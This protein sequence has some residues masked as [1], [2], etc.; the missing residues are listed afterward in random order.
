MKQRNGFT[1]VELL[2]VIAIIGVLVALLLPA[3]QAARE[4][5]RRTQCVNQIRQL[6][7]ACHNFHD[8]KKRFPSAGDQVIEGS[9]TKSTGLSWLAYILP[10]IEGQN[11]QNLV[12]ESVHWSHGNNDL[13]E[14]TVVPMFNCPTTGAELL[15]FTGNPGAT[16]ETVTSA[17][18]AQYVGIMGAKSTCDATLT[19]TKYPE[20]GYSMFLRHDG[21]GDFSGG[22]ANNG[23]IVFHDKVNMKGISDG[24]SNT[25]MI[26]E[27]SWDYGPTR[28]WIIGTL[29][30]NAITSVNPPA[31][32]GWIYNAK[33]V[34]W[35]MNTAYRE[36]IG[37]PPSGYLNNDTSLG[38][39]HPGGAHVGMGDGSAKFVEEDIDLAAL[40][41]LATRA[42]DDTQN[43]ALTCTGSGSGG[44]GGR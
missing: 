42:N 38:S 17:L 24:T 22:L 41:A 10:Y 15:I 30:K 33:N 28:S 35:P 25:M 16:A 5:A 20:S 1:L 4:A 31:G 21:S 37:D 27:S 12:D 18:R 40:K 2:V 8:S 26:G 14:Q 11:L 44:G 34:F 36:K 6:G 7:I 3:I 39:R 13:A 19:S 29:D 9:A 43:P 23:I 32:P